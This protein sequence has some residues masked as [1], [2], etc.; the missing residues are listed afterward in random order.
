MATNRSR[1][2]VAV[3][4]PVEPPTTNLQQPKND[5]QPTSKHPG[6]RHLGVG[7]WVFVGCWKLV[8]AVPDRCRLFQYTAI[9]VRIHSNPCP[10]DSPVSADDRSP[11]AMSSPA[12]G[13][14]V[15]DAA[16]SS[17][18]PRRGSPSPSSL[19]SWAPRST[20]PPRAPAS[21][22]RS[23]LRPLRMRSPGPPPPPAS[24]PPVLPRPPPPPPLRTPLLRRPL[25]CR[26]PR[27]RSNP[28]CSSLPTP[29]RPEPPS[30]PGPRPRSRR[31]RR[32]TWIFSSLR[33]RRRPNA[34]RPLRRRP[35]PRHPHCASQRLLR[36]RRW[37]SSSRPIP[38]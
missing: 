5:Q 2:S 21:R 25:R 14:A 27:C 4:T 9:D 33:I 15:R 38:R 34:P 20:G 23:P 1:P 10:S 18:F 31:L 7:R 28:T 30:P 6:H 29:R 26:C 16:T 36:V 12:S 35:S 3:S 8:V 19:P 22:R 32:M 17:W 24:R 13:F 11:P 37:I